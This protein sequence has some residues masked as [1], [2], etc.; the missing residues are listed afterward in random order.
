M[1]EEGQ[2]MYHL[3]PYTRKVLYERSKI[4]FGTKIYNKKGGKEKYAFVVDHLHVDFEG[5]VISW[6]GWYRQCG[7]YIRPC[8][9]GGQDTLGITFIYESDESLDE[10]RIELWCEDKFKQHKQ[11]LIND[12]YS[13]T[14]KSAYF[15]IEDFRESKLPGIYK[16]TECLPEILKKY[17]TKE[18][19]KIDTDKL[20]YLKYKGSG[21]SFV[22]NRRKNGGTGIPDY[23]VYKVKCLNCDEII[24]LNNMEE[25]NKINEA[26]KDGGVPFCLKDKT[27]RVEVIRNFY[28]E[29]K[30]D[31]DSL[32]QTQLDWNREHQ[33]RERVIVHVFRFDDKKADKEWKFIGRKF[34][35]GT[36]K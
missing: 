34:I 17:L 27:H 25:C 11:K 5:E 9:E 4:S 31:E 15:E 33:Q 8:E 23:R 18:D 16:L 19:N 10:L 28:D 14:S 24:G 21:Y 20:L 2:Y 3:K 30:I 22:T 32:R 12:D 13:N 35:K 7:Y 26:W 29:I 1:I 36:L 6:K